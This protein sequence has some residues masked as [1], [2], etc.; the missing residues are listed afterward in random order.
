MNKPETPNVKCVWCKTADA[1]KV[2]EPEWADNK[3]EGGDGI[4]RWMQTYTHD[5]CNSGGAAPFTKWSHGYLPEECQTASSRA[6]G[7]K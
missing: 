6:G 3:G 4:G 7:E 5:G 1:T 2:G